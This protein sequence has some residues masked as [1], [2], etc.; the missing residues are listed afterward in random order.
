MQSG[1]VTRQEGVQESEMRKYGQQHPIERGCVWHALSSPWGHRIDPFRSPPICARQHETLIPYL[2]P[3][4]RLLHNE[5]VNLRH[6]PVGSMSTPESP[7]NM[8]GQIP[9]LLATPPHAE[10]HIICV[11]KRKTEPVPNANEGVHL[12][13]PRWGK[14]LAGEGRHGKDIGPRAP[15]HEAIRTRATTN[16]QG[17]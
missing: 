4:R 10:M 3:R 8:M 11:A 12:L 5:G 17:A 16:E 6:K 13:A 2:Q 1:H 15:T 9:G 14:A 7:G